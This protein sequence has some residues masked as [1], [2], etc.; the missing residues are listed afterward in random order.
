MLI[1]DILKADHK[2][3]I[4]I[5]DTIGKVT[6]PG[7]R[8]SL[9]T[10]VHTELAMHS[11]AEEEVL[12]RTLSDRLED[13]EIIEHSFEDHDEIDHLLAKLQFGSAKDEEWTDNLRHLRAVLQ[14]H[15]TKE[16]TD[17]FNLAQH[18]FSNQEA[19]ELGTR[20]LEEKGKLGM[21]NPFMVA[22]RKFKEIV[23]G[24]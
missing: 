4:D 18:L 3:V 11:K 6:D 2:Q 23:S 7:R 8:K 13:D 10:L 5:I 24:E 14:R 17:V 21:P 22:A 12:Y 1:Y 19:E 20:M 15:I 9:I 16:E